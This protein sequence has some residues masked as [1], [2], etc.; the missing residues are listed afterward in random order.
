MRWSDSR[1]RASRTAANASNRRSFRSSPSSSRCRNSAV[2][3]RSSASESAWNSGS[4]V[5]MYEACSARRFM[6]RPSPM[7]RNFS[8]PVPMA[9][10]TGYRLT[11][12]RRLQRVRLDLPEVGLDATGADD[13]IRALEGRYRA[14]NLLVVDPQRSRAAVDRE[15]DPVAVDTGE[16]DHLDAPGGKG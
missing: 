16:L 8:K 5:A 4:S 7:R 1:R 9:M 3:A 10:L 6:R 15:L 14:K 12:A 13:V 2:F 11:P